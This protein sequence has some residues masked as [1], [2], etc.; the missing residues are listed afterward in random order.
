MPEVSDL[1]TKVLFKTAKAPEPDNAGMIAALKNEPPQEDVMPFGVGGPAEPSGSPAGFLGKVV[2]EPFHQ[3]KRLI[4]ASANAVPGLRP[5]DYT[6]NPKAPHPNDPMYDAARDMS[7]NLMGTGMPFAQ[8]GAAG[9]FGGRLSKTADQKMADL[10]ERMEA[11]GQ[12]PQDIRKMTGWEHSPLDDMWKYEIPD[13]KLRLNY[14]PDAGFT[15]SSSAASMFDHPELFK[16]YPHLRDLKTSVSRGPVGTGGFD[17]ATNR[18]H[19]EVPDYKTGRSVGAHEL[20]HGVQDFEGF[21]PGTNPGVWGDLIQKNM[22]QDRLGLVNMN[23]LRDEA[24]AGY[25]GTA[26][27]VEARNVQQRL[28]YNPLERLMR[29][30]LAEQFA[31]TPTQFV[32]TPRTQEIIRVLRHDPNTNTYTRLD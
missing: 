28:D 3:I 15:A 8:K 11:R 16:A 29:S 13:N 23:R 22:P 26:G 12:H 18:L 17:P 10:A 21:A 6:D 1:L 2:S 30:P 14:V 5:E 32:M 20:M 27:E 4:D 7:L 31:D 24:M 25:K 19:M 9:I